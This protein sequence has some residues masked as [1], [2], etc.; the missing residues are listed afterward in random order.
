MLLWFV[1][2]IMLILVTSYLYFGL[3]IME[4]SCIKIQNIG[5]SSLC[6]RSFPWLVTLFFFLTF[7]YTVW[8]ILSFYFSLPLIFESKGCAKC[9]E[10]LCAYGQLSFLMVLRMGL[11]QIFFRVV[12]FEKRV[13]VV[14]EEASQIMDL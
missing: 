13:L 2:T 7:F 12:S 4:G 10:C 9:K 1:L 14:G 5:L 8:G 11:V 6:E 3:S